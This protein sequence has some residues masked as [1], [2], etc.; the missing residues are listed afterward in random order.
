MS[1]SDS[2][3]ANRTK[4]HPFESDSPILSKQAIDNEKILSGPYWGELRTFLAIAKSKSLTR[5]AEH[6]NTSHMT[7]GRELRRLQ[8]R[9]G[10]QLAVVSQSGVRITE[11]GRELAK[12][13]LQF[14]Q[15]LFSVANDLRTETKFSEGIVRVSITDGLGVA[16]MVPAIER[17]VHDFPKLHIHLKSTSNLKSLRENQT[18]IMLGF[19]EEEASDLTSIPLGWLHFLPV[20]SKVYIAAHGMPDL[21]SLGGHS[22]V[23][24]ELYS[25]KSPVWQKWQNLV[26]EGQT[27]CQCDSSVSYGMMVKKGVG[28]GLLGNYILFDPAF[29]PLELDCRLSLRMYLIWVTER[30][31]S[32]PVRIVKNL[33]ESTFGPSNPWFSETIHL[34]CKVPS[35]NIGLA[36]FSNL[37]VQT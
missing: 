34:E 19:A 1:P 32:K 18:D 16:F 25:A 20:A 17:L 3:A 5:A 15:T 9:I 33:M 14:D 24:S 30:L 2:V 13:L 31:E 36:N 35:Y 7:V 22:F 21:S 26:L 37:P 28:I 8:D 11:R 23:D 12:L 4:D 29:V 10:A 27:A 6:L